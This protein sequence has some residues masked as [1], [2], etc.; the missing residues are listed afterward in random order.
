[1]RQVNMHEAK[2][3]LSRLIEAA[4]AG[5]RVVIARAGEPVAEIVPL[6]RQRGIRI[7]LLK[8]KMPEAFV[9]EFEQPWSREQLDQLFGA[10]IEPSAIEPCPIKP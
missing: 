8:G 10:P 2:S 7:G 5:E 1:M 4:E 3:T 9:R 6:K